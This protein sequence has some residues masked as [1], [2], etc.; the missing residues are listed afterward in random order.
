MSETCRDGPWD[1]S[2]V[3]EKVMEKDSTELSKLVNIYNIIIYAIN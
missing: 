1:T 3:M 2:R